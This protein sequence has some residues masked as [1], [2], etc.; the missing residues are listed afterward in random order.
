MPDYTDREFAEFV[1]DLA[2]RLDVGGAE[3]QGKSF[4]KTP[5]ELVDEIRAELIDVAGWAFILLTRIN[6][7]KAKVEVSGSVLPPGR[8]SNGKVLSNGIEN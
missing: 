3:Y 1:S 2:S 8:E 5:N 4:Q 6:R 7:L